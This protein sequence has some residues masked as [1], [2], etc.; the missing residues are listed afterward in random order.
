LE[1]GL[2]CG[3]VGCSCGWRHSV[4]DNFGSNRYLDQCGVLRGYLESVPTSDPSPNLDADGVTG[5]AIHNSKR[6]GILG[7]RHP[8]FVLLCHSEY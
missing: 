2:S 8:A 5:S 7:R 3:W 1:E 6:L 4:P